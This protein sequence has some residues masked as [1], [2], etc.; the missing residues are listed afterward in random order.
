MRQEVGL[1][2]PIC[3]RMKRLVLA[4]LLAALAPLLPASGEE[5][6]MVGKWRASNGYKI[7][8]PRSSQN[9]GLVFEDPQGK[10]IDH[11][12]QWVT[13]GQKFSWIDKQGSEH[14]ATFDSHYKSPRIRDV[15]SA[16]PSS[17]AYWYR[18]P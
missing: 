1:R 5:N 4:F 13:R 12:A 14:T 10:K 18:L 6:P 8:I 16:Y 2:Q 7:H 17:P 11:P 9:F 15:N 3:P